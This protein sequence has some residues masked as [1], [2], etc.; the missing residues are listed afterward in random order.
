MNPFIKK[1][2]RKIGLM[3]KKNSHLMIFTLSIDPRKAN[4][5][6]L[7]GILAQITAAVTLEKER[8]EETTI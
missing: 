7:D 5:K 6:E 4:L 2:L 1:C 3:K 8:L